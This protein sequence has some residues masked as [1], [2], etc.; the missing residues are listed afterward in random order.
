MYPGRLAKMSH[1]TGS[2][3]VMRRDAFV[4]FSA[5]DDWLNALA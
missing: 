3:V 1:I 2:G 5:G 4:D